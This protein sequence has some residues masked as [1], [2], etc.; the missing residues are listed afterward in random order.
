MKI[1]GIYFNG[2][3]GQRVVGQNGI[4]Q[5]EEVPAGNGI[6]HH[7]LIIYDYGIRER[8]FNVTL[9]EYFPNEGPGQVKALSEQEV[10]DI[11]SSAIYEQKK[12]PMVVLD[13]VESKEC[14]ACQ[15]TGFMPGLKSLFNNDMCMK[16]GGWGK[17]KIEKNIE[18]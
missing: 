16:C 13:R 3:N 4:E 17:I 5:I 1:K 2:T 12:Q 11:V 6:P 8:L 14:E 10:A 9:V 18:E 7:F 15:G